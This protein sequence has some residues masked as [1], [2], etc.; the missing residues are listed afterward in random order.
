[1]NLS[2]HSTIGSDSRGYVTKDVYAHYGKQDIKIAVVTGIHPREEVSVAPVQWAS[3]AFT[4]LPVEVA[5]YSINVEDNPM[6]YRKGR[7]SGEGLATTY[8]LPDVTKSDYDLVII[9]HA[10]A[11]GYG[12]GFY[13]ATP[14][15]DE[16]SVRIAEDLREEGFNYYPVSGKTV[17]RSS[18]A[19]L[20]SRPLAA[21][22]YPTLVYE[23]PEWSSAYEV[24]FMTLKLLRA[25]SSVLS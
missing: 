2:D 21:A 25:T 18:S 14:Q 1:M 24:F 6:D 11:P 23:V 20:F 22:G 15:M 13:V 9:A 16:P 3:R 17:Y 19:R 7:A 8:I 10:H 12:E 4:L 5:L